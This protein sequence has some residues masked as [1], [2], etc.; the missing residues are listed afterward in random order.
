MAA[1]HVG[2]TQIW[3]LAHR[4]CAR[5]LL[6]LRDAAFNVSNGFERSPAPA[7]WERGQVSM[8]GARAVQ[9]GQSLAAHAATI[10]LNRE[11]APATAPLAHHDSGRKRPCYSAA[12]GF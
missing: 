11:V 10:V 2:D 7:R 8:G 6:V 12:S 3:H 1:L 9:F 5:P 4:S